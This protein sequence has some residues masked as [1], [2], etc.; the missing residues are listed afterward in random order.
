LVR[1]AILQE[2]DHDVVELYEPHVE[3]L[4]AAPQVW[5]ADSPRI[6]A[7][8][9]GKD[10]LV[11][12]QRVLYGVALKVTVPEHFCPTEDFGI[13]FICPFHVLH[14]EAEMLYALEPGT[15]QAFI[16]G[17]DR[18]FL[19]GCRCVDR[20]GGRNTA[21]RNA[22]GGAQDGTTIGVVELDS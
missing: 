20:K 9:I 6:D 14:C 5:H 12:E 7:E 11:G 17:D 19:S 22:S 16:A 18:R 2:L 1:I 10:F 3:A 15:Q 8:F 4:G 21:N 13:E